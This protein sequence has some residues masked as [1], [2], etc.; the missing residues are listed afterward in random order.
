MWTCLPIDGAPIPRNVASMDE[1]LRMV[2]S[3]LVQRSSAA[4][5]ER[6]DLAALQAHTG[7]RYAQVET[8]PDSLWQSMRQLQGVTP[9]VLLPS[10]TAVANGDAVV[11]F[12][13]QH[14]GIK[15][16]PVNKRASMVLKACG[17]T[18]EVRGE[19]F[20][21][22]VL[23]TGETSPS[24]L[25]PAFLVER[26]WLE[27]AQAANRSRTPGEAQNLEEKLRQ[28]LEQMRRAQVAESV[29][30]ALP[31]QQS[32]PASETPPKATASPTGPAEAVAAEAVAV[33]APAADA[34][35]GCA[36][37]SWN[38]GGDEVQVTVRV[39]PGTKAKHVLCTIK[40]ASLKLEVATLPAAQRVV[41]DGKLFQECVHA[42]RGVLLRR[43]P[44]YNSGA[45]TRPCLLSSI[46][47]RAPVHVHGRPSVAS[48][49]WE[50]TQLGCMR[51][52][53]RLPSFPVASPATCA[54]AAKTHTR[55]CNRCLQG[56]GFRL[57]LVRGGRQRG[58]APHC[59]LSREEEE[60]ALVDAHAQ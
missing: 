57:Q 55:A 10:G 56:R 51:T 2:S 48:C 7:S 12:V 33:A 27:A 35:D 30:K 40:D 59:H 6:V 8:V 32:V 23:S 50:R 47:A 42:W 3:H 15:G 25:A 53:T 38:D 60:D 16:L 37:M 34:V 46:Y 45:Y 36:E 20:V 21:G 28:R 49:T 58:D 18:G 26:D 5:K 17:L 29:A 39:P 14:G 24:E 41:V 52:R 31:S 9:L 11:C 19:C 22:R 43:A 4:H 1:G 44:R 54:S 13:D